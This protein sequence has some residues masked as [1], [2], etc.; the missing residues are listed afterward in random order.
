MDNQLGRAHVWADDW[1]DLGAGEKRFADGT[2]RILK[3]CETIARVSPHLGTFGITRVAN[4]TGLDRIGIPV[5]MVMRPNSRSV[6]VAQGK[7]VTLDAAKAS[8]LMEAIESWHAERI[9]LPVMFGRYRDLAPSYDLVAPDVLPQ[10]A[11]SPYTPDMRVQW[12]EAHDLINGG[13]CW[14]PYEMV[15]TDYTF[16][17]PQG[18]GCFACSS[19][20]LASGNSLLEATVHAICEVVERDATALWSLSGLPRQARRR[21]DLASVDDPRARHVLE[22]ISEAGL[23][24]A[25]WETT[26]D[27]GVPA[28][29][30]L[31]A[32]DEHE[33]V[34]EG[35]GCHPDKAVALSRTLC[36]AV[37]T[38]MTYISGAR[39]DMLRSEF[40][41]AGMRRK[42]AM[43]ARLMAAGP[44][45]VHY[46][47]IE[48]FASSTL[49]QDMDAL[50]G[51]LDACGIA[52]VAAIDLSKP[53]YGIAVVRVVI[54]GLE[55]P[56]DDDGFVPGARAQAALKAGQ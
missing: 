39:D 16:P 34:G 47:R 5:V 9:D 37:Q 6:A 2:H 13:T 33:H 3:P 45:E 52:R 17:V 24:V 40:E 35:A 19:N 42:Q 26:S 43:A 50:I 38:R 10:V 11:G 46:G 4:V 36:E 7:G 27:L 32:G 54:P 22:R 20:G 41:A 1:A 18:H 49:G 48:G 55:S 30:A 15:H 44:G 53:E 31:L 23:D 14:V 25:V 8:G 21:L 51:R 12:I 28:F 56:H 29:Y